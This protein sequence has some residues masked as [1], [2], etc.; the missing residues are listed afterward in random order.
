MMCEMMEMYKAV[1]FDLDGTLLDTSLGII[2][3]VKYAIK[4]NGY[5]ELDNETM[6]SFI[7]PPIQKSFARV[8]GV[9]KE[10]AD[11]VAADFRNHY[12]TVDLFK[13][14]LY[15]DIIK[16]LKLLKSKNIKI[17]VATYKREDYAKKL[18]DE[19]GITPYC[20]SIIG[21]DFEGKLTK[22]DII[23]L[24]IEELY[25]PKGNVVMVGDT[26]HDLDGAKNI[27][28]DFIAVTYGFG[29]KPNEEIECDKICNKPMDIIDFV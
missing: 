22:S 18:L 27:N 26:V 21:S 12:S 9:S 1:I 15:N 11:K 20:D 13:A 8:Y 16:L 3:S 24:C 29:F 25:E 17:G 23:N 10:E 2:S 14:E 7:G 6:N 5:D 4:K 28:V 19:F